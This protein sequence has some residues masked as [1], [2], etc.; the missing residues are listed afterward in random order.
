MAR[1][2]QRI[3]G[4]S[5]TS[6]SCV[7]SL[8]QDLISLAQFNVLQSA[9]TSSDCPL[10]FCSESAFHSIPSRFFRVMY[11]PNSQCSSPILLR[12]PAFRISTPLRDVWMPGL[13]IPDVLCTLP[14]L[15]VKASAF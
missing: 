13:L 4:A 3:F 10:C 5:F 14:P 7:M 9:T 15:A 2:A 12:T 8:Q 11:F 1:L 6:E